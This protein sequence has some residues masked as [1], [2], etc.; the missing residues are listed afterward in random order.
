MPYPPSKEVAFRLDADRLALF[1]VDMQNDFVRVGAPLEVPAA[2][3]TIGAIQELTKMARAHGI[4]VFYT[5]FLAGPEYT[6]LWEWSPMAGPETKCCW[7]DHQ[8]YYPD[9][10]RHAECSAVIDE[11]TPQPEDVIIDKFGYSA[12]FN[13]NAAEHLRARHRDMIIVAG[14]VTQICVEDTIRSAFHHGIRAVAAR[15]GVSSFD[16]EL[17]RSTLRGIDMKY[18]RVMSN[19]EIAAELTAKLHPEQSI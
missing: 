2:R 13:T 8:R 15:D 17:H 6:L 9:I 7:I 5:R 4:P 18:G 12:F 11:L 3:D 16:D 19:A 1:V 14:T 10:K